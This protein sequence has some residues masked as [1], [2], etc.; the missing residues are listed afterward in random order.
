MRVR[1]FPFFSNYRDNVT[2]F[3]PGEDV[4]TASHEGDDEF[5]YVDGTSFASPVVAGTIAIFIGYEGI[6]DDV[7]KVQDRLRDN[8]Q[9]NVLN[10]LPGHNPI[11]NILANTG[12]HNPKREVYHPYYGPEGRELADEGVEQANGRFDSQTCGSRL[13]TRSGAIP[14]GSA[15]P[16]STLGLIGEPFI[17]AFTLAISPRVDT[18]ATPVAASQVVPSP[19]NNPPQ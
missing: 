6:I 5:A 15:S 11:P 3:A 18:R 1:L 7:K 8:W 17:P 12:L 19:T 9:R 4:W 2:L 13:T 10:S 14:G 16:A